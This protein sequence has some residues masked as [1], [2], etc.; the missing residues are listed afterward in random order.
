MTDA[1]RDHLLHRIERLERSNRFWKGL[2]LIGTPVLALLFLAAALTSVS[3]FFALRAERR[4]ALDEY[5]LAR[6]QAEREVMRAQQALEQAEASRQEARQAAEDAL[7]DAEKA[8]RD[9]ENEQ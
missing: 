4:Q 2:A 9:A 7:R 6:D 5:H 1:E 3:S 8:L